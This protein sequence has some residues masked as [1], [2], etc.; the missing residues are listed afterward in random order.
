[1]ARHHQA[2]TSRQPAT[3]GSRQQRS[4]QSPVP[5]PG[6]AAPVLEVS[7]LA[8]MF[9][10]VRAVD[11]ISFA[12]QPGQTVGLIGP[13][14]SGKTTAFNLISGLLRPDSGAILFGGARINGLRPERIAELGLARTFQNG[15]VFGNMTVRDNV[16]VGMHARLR[17][18]RPAPRWRYLPL[19]QWG[20]LVAEAVVALLRPPA[21]RREEA[22]LE[23]EV[24]ERLALFGERLLP[25][26]EHLAHSLSYANRRRV[27][28][29]RALALRPRLL[30]LDEPTA[31]MNPT[32]TAEVLDQ[33]LALRAAGQT[34]VLI[35]HKLDLVMTLSD[36][37]LVMDGGKLIA[38]GPPA[39]VQADE[40]VIEA[41]LG[42]GRAALSQAGAG[43]GA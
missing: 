10:G 32:E 27:E 22:A 29:A 42:R 41:Y 8:R 19:A 20:P 12:V 17:A 28:I 33:L 7:D 34:M 35:E 3:A 37:V 23:R 40:R 6:R 30:L 26:K 25:R 9:G 15:R 14:G 31:G 24:D 21:V 36:H 39:S 2:T 1:M 5:S 18:A 43:R 11:G 16:L 4:P 38:A 13:N